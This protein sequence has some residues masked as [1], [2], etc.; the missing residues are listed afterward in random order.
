MQNPVSVSIFV[1]LHKKLLAMTVSDRCLTLQSSPIVFQYKDT[2]LNKQEEIS[3]LPNYEIYCCLYKPDW[4]VLFP[5]LRSNM[6]TFLT[7]TCKHTLCDT[8]CSP[9]SWFGHRA[10]CCTV[11]SQIH[12]APLLLIRFHCWQPNGWCPDFTRFGAL[13][14]PILLG[15]WPCQY[16]LLLTLSWVISQG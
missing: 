6:L 12:S 7:L 15:I 3:P 8:T 1:L 13:Q 10:T 4:L 14:I 5:C 16:A 9:P 11:A 2:W